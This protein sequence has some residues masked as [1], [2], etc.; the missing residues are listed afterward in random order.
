MSNDLNGC[1]PCDC[2]VGGAMGDTCDVTN[3][4]C[5]CKRNITGRQCHQV[6]PGFYFTKMDLYTYEA[7]F[8]KGFGVRTSSF[9]CVT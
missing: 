8:A 1:R 7:E 4:Q 3:G 6:Q 9:G 2:D 5:I